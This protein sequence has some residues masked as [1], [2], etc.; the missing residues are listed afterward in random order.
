MPT[1]ETVRGPVDVT[2]LG[3]TLMH[4]HVVLLQQE[5]FDNYSHAWGEPYWEEERGVADAVAKLRRAKT[6]GIDTIVDPTAP[7]LGRFI[8]RVQRIN[9]QVPDLNILVCSGFYGFLELPSFLAYRTDDQI[10]ELFVREIRE[11][12]N[13]TGVKAAFLK[14]A[15]EKEGMIG[16]VPR[17]L[18]TVSA[19]QV[20]TGVPLMVHTS[21]PARG[22]LP[23]VERL[24][25]H[26][27]APEKI[28]IAHA[29]DSN[30]L[31]YLRALADQGVWLG[32]DRFQIE[33]FNPDADRVRT[34]ATLVAEGYAPQIQLG[35]D[36]SCFYD[37]MFENPPFADE[38][39]DYLHIRDKILPQLLDAGVTQEHIDTMLIDNPRRFFS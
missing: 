31:D 5:M 19:A 20:E 29:G 27:V 39:P 33:H 12:I 17:I 26:G 23:V 28:V 24:L 38:R 36:A 4:E 13:D 18:A 14:A 21:A 35:H 32:C 10:V 8:P 3:T 34:L 6:G 1:V 7:G 25:S 37:F 30:D 9:E 22:G 11:G 15:V 16:D 2:E